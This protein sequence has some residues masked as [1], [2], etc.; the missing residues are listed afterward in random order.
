MSVWIG[1][2]I[3]AAVISGLITA[4]GWWASHYSSRRIETS[5]RSERVKDIQTALRAE[6]RSHRQRLLLFADGQ[7]TQST[8]KRIAESD[9]SGRFTPFVPR[10]VDS[11][12][13]VAVAKEVHIL[14]TA[15][16]DPVV[17]YYR[18]V[19]A[20][21]QFAEDM[22]SERFDNLEPARKAEMYADYVS[23]GVYALQLAEEAI[24]AIDRSLVDED[25]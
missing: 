21:A 15:V 2:A 14:P 16:I 7:A 9:G 4:L 12:I 20:L 13:F 25:Q 22:R 18:Q 3:V 8:S 17:L 24:Q 6:M 23:L 5:R 10:E 11:F 19:H 1:P